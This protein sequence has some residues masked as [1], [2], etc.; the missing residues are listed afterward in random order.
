MTNGKSHPSSR[1]SSAPAYRRLP[2]ETVPDDLLPKRLA[3][4]I[5]QAFPS[6]P[7][8]TTPLVAVPGAPTGS[9]F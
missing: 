4:V 1:L 8:V 5:L 9:F 7:V 2:S 3:L 6:L